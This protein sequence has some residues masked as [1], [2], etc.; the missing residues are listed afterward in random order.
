[1]PR[2]PREEVPGGVYHVYSRGNRKEPIFHDAHDYRE[3]LGMFGLA[4]REYRWRPLA[5][6]LMGNHL[7]HLIE[8]TDTNLGKG[9]G[10]VHSLYARAFN[11]RHQTGGGHLFQKRYGCTRARTTGALM[12]MACYVLLNPVKAGL[13]RRPEQHQWSSY[14]STLEPGGTETWLDS[15]RLLDYF[16]SKSTFAD[17]VDAVRIMGAAGFEP[18]TC[19]V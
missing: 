14:A 11:E 13:C 15:E 19:L 2:R 6:C 3:Y 12:Y 8:I 9:I 7:H 5:Y 17:I 10:R 18:A 4:A 1:M 16:D